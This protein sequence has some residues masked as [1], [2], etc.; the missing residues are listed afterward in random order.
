MSLTSF[1]FPILACMIAYWAINR[2][3]KIMDVLILGG[4]LLVIS[5]IG[6][7]AFSALFENTV[8]SMINIQRIWFIG[9]FIFA[10]KFGRIIKLPNVQVKDNNKMFMTLFL[11]L[12]I[13]LIFFLFVPETITF[14]NISIG[15]QS[16]L[17]GI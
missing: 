12:I 13:A 17:V 2:D 3:K 10:M 5:A 1:I 7:Y 4:W 14:G 6:F 11:A 15:T 8:I 16:V 9:M